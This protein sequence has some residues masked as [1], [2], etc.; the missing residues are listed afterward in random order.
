MREGKRQNITFLLRRA[1]ESTMESFASETY[2]DV[3]LRTYKPIIQSAHKTLKSSVNNAWQIFEVISKR[4]HNKKPANKEI[5]RI[6]HNDVAFKTLKESLRS[7]GIVTNFAV[8]QYLPQH[9]M[10]KEKCKLGH[11]S[12]SDDTR[13]KSSAPLSSDWLP[14]DLIKKETN[15]FKW[16][17]QSSSQPSASRHQNIRIYLTAEDF[18]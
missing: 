4:N 11:C 14:I 10:S 1:S 3:E 12:R 2:M 13:V 6:V 17:N 16:K 9:Q 18:E 8:Q 15:G 7:N 5:S